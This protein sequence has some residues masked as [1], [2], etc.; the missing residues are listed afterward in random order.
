MEKRWCMKAMT[1]LDSDFSFDQGS[2]KMGG[3]TDDYSIMTMRNTVDDTGSDLLTWEQGQSDR[4]TSGG[5]WI[6]ILEMPG[7]Q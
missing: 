2:V 4:K 7:E 1:A 6:N 3:N 5:P